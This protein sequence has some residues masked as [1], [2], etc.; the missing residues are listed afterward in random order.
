MMS[1]INILRKC[2]KVFITSLCS[3]YPFQQQ[4]GNNKYINLETKQ[5]AI[6]CH[7]TNKINSYRLSFTRS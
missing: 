2:I 7:S 5:I 4:I 1:L 6:Y 3:D